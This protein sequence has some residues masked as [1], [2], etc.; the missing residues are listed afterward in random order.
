MSNSVNTAGMITS[1]LK[2]LQKLDCLH[3]ESNRSKFELKLY[4]VLFWNFWNLNG[5]S[6]VKD[7]FSQ[8]F[9]HF[10]EIDK[11]FQKY[12]SS[13]VWCLFLIRFLLYKRGAFGNSYC[14]PK[15]YALKSSSDP[16][17]KCSRWR[18]DPTTI[19]WGRLRRWKSHIPSAQTTY[20]FNLYY[21]IAVRF[22]TI[23]QLGVVYFI[24]KPW[25]GRPFCD[26]IFG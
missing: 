16:G 5:P 25:R 19:F 8:I 3:F 9:F 14:E 20:K 17:G 18:Q 4:L 11:Q 7:L 12:I 10:G 1:R 21:D 22:S 23:Y 6:K 13:I 26:M 24:L 15:N 2:A